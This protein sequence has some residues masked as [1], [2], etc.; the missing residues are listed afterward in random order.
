MSQGN[1]IWKPL[2]NISRGSLVVSNELCAQRAMPPV[3]CW[4]RA[5]YNVRNVGRDSFE[6][7]HW[8]VASLDYDRLRKVK[9]LKL[10]LE[11]CRATAF[12]SLS[13]ACS[14]CSWATGWFDCH[15][16]CMGARKNWSRGRDRGPLRAHIWSRFCGSSSHKEII[17]TSKHRLSLEQ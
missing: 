9:W 7:T 17:W 16:E 10:D 2:N 14:A 4:L 1:W 8:W 5:Q 12:A 11:L 15:R 6:S 3:N 13:S